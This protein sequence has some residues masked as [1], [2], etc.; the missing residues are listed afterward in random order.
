MT[1][2]RFDNPDFLLLE[3]WN[4]AHGKS[5]PDRADLIDQAGFVVEDDDGAAAIAFL[6]MAGPVAMV[7]ALVS[8]PGMSMKVSREASI[9]LDDWITQQAKNQGASRLVA[10]VSSRGMVRETSRLGY[11][12]SGSP[13]AQMIKTL[14]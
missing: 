10:F 2:R 4:S 6:F 14:N 8:R 3:M 7:E 12:Q 11:R 9:I 5:A 13:M 1:L